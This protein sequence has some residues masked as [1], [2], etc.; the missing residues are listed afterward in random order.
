M[1]Y[2]V[3]SAEFFN[4][5]N[6]FKKGLTELRDFRADTLALGCD[7]IALRG[8]AEN[9]ELAGFLAAAK[10]LDW[11]LIHTIS[12][13]AA[14]AGPVSREAFDY[15]AGIICDAARG[16]KG[17]LD[18]ILLG[19]HGAQVV[20]FCEDGEGELLRRLREIVGP[21]LPIAVTLD[22]H[23]NATREMVELAQ[24]W[25]SYKTYPHVDIRLAGHRAAHLLHAAMAGR[26]RPETLRRA[27]PM[28]E[29]A[30]SGR[31]DMGPMVAAY[32]RARAEEAE[33]GILSVSINA[34]YAE[35][36]I[37]EV[38]PSVLVTYDRAV[39][40][41]ELRAAEI[42]DGHS[43]AI[44]E[45]RHINGNDYLTVEE[46]AR[47]ARN[48]DSSH[49]PLVIA[50]Y[51]DNPGAGA[52]GD[53]TNLLSALLEAGVKNAAF[54]PMVDPEL[55]RELHRHREGEVVT[56]DLGG[57]SDPGFGGGPLRLTGRIM[58]L[59]DGAFRGDGPMLGGLQRSFGTTAVLRVEGI[60]I[61]VVTEPEQLLDRQQLVA[62]GIQPQEKSVL[63]LKSM[64]HFRAAFEPIAGEVIVCD[65]GALATPEV[66][67]K[68][69][70]KVRRPIWPLDPETVY[71][72]GEA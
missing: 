9:T 42:A 39:P 1:P 19:L 4:E 50:D 58:K 43:R 15:V 22:L 18:G 10:E 23:A 46:A 41:A 27:P 57:K 45:A 55:A 64:Q 48:F 53:A 32:T 7:A 31:S 16:H 28:L 12:A 68:P 72:G 20:E 26:T 56:V 65:S 17:R 69:F 29:E 44:W 2:T 54:A 33:P 62:F 40:G 34:G 24:I 49:G 59:S 8:L 60:D 47:I 63:S 35:A 66:T 52:Y 37:R 21:D 11:T 6:T 70:R 25:V 3:L 36:D 61:L 71:T 51:A 30:T 13:T 67:R 5:N 38:G 14:P